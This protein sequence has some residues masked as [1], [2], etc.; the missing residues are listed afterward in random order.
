[1]VFEWD[2]TLVGGIQCLNSGD[3]IATI[4]DHVDHVD[5]IRLQCER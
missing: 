2:P 4:I 5:Q 3:V 1:M